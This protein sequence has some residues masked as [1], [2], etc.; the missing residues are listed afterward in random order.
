[1]PALGRGGLCKAHRGFRFSFG[2]LLLAVAGVLRCLERVE[3]FMSRASNRGD[4]AIERRLVSLGGPRGTAQLAHE[5]K[6]RLMD[7]LV[8]CRRLKVEQ[9][10]DVP[11]HG[12][13]PRI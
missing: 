7:F 13:A 12:L 11:A 1:M 9:G 8:R 5:L 2:G 4:S 10:F 3:K 6:C